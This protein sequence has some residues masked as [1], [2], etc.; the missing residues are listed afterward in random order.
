VKRKNE[1]PKVDV[2]VVG[3]IGLDTIQTPVESGRDLLG[4]SVSY[5]CA[6]ASFFGPVGMVGVV[7]DDFPKPYLRLYRRFGIDLAGLQQVAGR[8]FRWSGV[9]EDNM[10]SRRTLS[11]E[12]NVFE[13]F[14][15]E[16]PPEYRTARHLLLGN[17][18]PELQ[19]HVLEQVRGCRFVVADTMDLWIRIARPAL[20]RLVKRVD[21]LTLNDSEAQQLTGESNLVKAAQSVLK[22]GPR[23]AVIKKGEH[24][25]MLVSPTGLFLVPAFPVGDVCDPTGAGD[26]FA[27]GFLGALGRAARIDE[28][29]LCRALL[30]GSVVASFGVQGLSLSALERVKRP[31]IERRLAALKSMSAW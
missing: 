29:A 10:N 27:G 26:S 20:L 23:Y 30:Y 31:A 3:S 25:A 17:I 7:G 19:Q 12:L 13:S 9:Y 11:T 24:G 1:R 21:M 5:A 6:A 16:L 15:P 2:V 4:G 14:R 18:S 22:L 8:T 28:R